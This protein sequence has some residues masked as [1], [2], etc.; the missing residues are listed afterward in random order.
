MHVPYK[1]AAL[2]TVARAGGEV[3]E[4]IGAR[5][6]REVIRALEAPDMRQ[7]LTAAGIDPWPGSPEDMARL[8]HSETARYAKI[9]QSAGM[10]R[11]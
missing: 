6:S 3:D 11:Q 10:R 7:R 5:L 2:A 1:G 4:T 8:V 9:V